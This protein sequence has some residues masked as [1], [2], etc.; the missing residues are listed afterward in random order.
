METVRITRMDIL[1]GSTVKAIFSAAIGRIVV[2]KLVLILHETG[3]NIS[4]PRGTK[5]NEEEKGVIELPADLFEELRNKAF[6]T[7]TQMTGIELPRQPRRRDMQPKT[8]PVDDYSSVRRVV[9]A[10]EAEIARAG[11]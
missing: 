8:T 4:F 6:A 9:G 5:A 10:A 1:A 7:Y 2:K 3:A 11:I